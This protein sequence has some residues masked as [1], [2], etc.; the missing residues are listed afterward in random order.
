MKDRQTADEER[1]KIL[2]S[3]YEDLKDKYDK[4]IH[5]KD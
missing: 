1:F 3:K 2:E 4:L 5:K